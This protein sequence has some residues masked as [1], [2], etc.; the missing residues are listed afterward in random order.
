MPGRWAHLYETPRWRKMRAVHL[1]EH[2]HCVMCLERGWDTPATVVDHRQPHRGD[3][4]LFFDP[5]NLQSLCKPHH[6]SN[7]QREERHGITPGCDED[8]N[9][10]DPRHPWNQRQGSAS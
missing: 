6:D 8:G 2:P 10:V 7:K 3:T 1:H 4:R 9:P 5:N